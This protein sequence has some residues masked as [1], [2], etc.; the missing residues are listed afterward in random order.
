MHNSSLITTFVSILLLLSGVSWA[1]L[2]AYSA[3]MDR[4]MQA[5]RD[6]LFQAGTML[7]S[8]KECSETGDTKKVVH[9]TGLNQEQFD[10]VYAA[11]D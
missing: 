2:Y 6:L 5:A 3:R 10:T 11:H 9:L 7:D 4:K 8:L 1:N